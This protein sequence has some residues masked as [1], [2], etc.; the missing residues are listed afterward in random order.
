MNSNDEKKA[1]ITLDEVHTQAE[2]ISDKEK[3]ELANLLSE[4]SDVFAKDGNKPGRT[5][6]VEHRIDMIRGSR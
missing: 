6:M 1:K 5:N 4:Y 3:L 2:I